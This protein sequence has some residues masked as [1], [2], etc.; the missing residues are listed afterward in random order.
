MSMD[1]KKLRE[2]FVVLF[3]NSCTYISIPQCPW[4]L[5]PKYSNGKFTLKPVTPNMTTTFS[6]GICRIKVNPELSTLRPFSSNGNF[7]GE[8]SNKACVDK[9]GIY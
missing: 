8:F 7:R 3:Y 2:L 9:S 1:S 5:F 6:F 4:V